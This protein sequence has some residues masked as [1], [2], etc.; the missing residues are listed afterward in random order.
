M[1]AQPAPVVS[2]RYI[3]GDR[4]FECT[5][6]IPLDRGGISSKAGAEAVSADAGPA[7]TPANENPVLS[8]ASQP[9]AAPPRAFRS[10]RREN[11]RI[12]FFHS[13]DITRPS[14]ACGLIFFFAFTVTYTSGVPGA[15]LNL[16][17]AN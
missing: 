15:I 12:R 16:C 8:D 9:K 3:S 2:G 17:C 11:E 4:P 10:R 7:A 5:H 14:K 13:P 1:N 6:V